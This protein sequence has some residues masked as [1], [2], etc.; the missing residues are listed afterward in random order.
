MKI[1]HLM[2]LRDEH[3]RVQARLGVLVRTVAMTTP[4][5]HQLKEIRD[6]ED[7]RSSIKREIL[8]IIFTS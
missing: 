3:R 6:L 5:P 4:M 7:R 8:Q 1:K 2:Q